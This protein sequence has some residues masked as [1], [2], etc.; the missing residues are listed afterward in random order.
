MEQMETQQYL[1]FTVGGEEYAIGILSVREI[2]AY[3]AVT[4]VPKA[5]AWIRG[6]TNVR[7]SV[8]PV[9][10]L[11]IKLGVGQT[12]PTP[13]TCIIVVDALA[14]GETTRL[15]LMAESVT[16]VIDLSADDIEPPPTLGTHI[17]TS[18]L[19]GVGRTGGAKFAL[20][21]DIDAVLT[22]SE[23][24]D[25]VEVVDAHAAAEE[26]LAEPA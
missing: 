3:G 15:G 18:Y 16:Q 2:L 5:A 14:D 24:A 20:I 25:A 13:W 17:D 9:V 4:T 1:T 6:V 19:L 23:T 10:D 11:G 22:R 12:V 26:S 7:G 21:L 8:V